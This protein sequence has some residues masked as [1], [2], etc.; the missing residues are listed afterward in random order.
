ML[1]LA[2]PTDQAGSPVLTQKLATYISQ[3]SPIMVRTPL[4]PFH[5]LCFVHTHPPQAPLTQV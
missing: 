1:L 5:T 3:G 2:A 4:P